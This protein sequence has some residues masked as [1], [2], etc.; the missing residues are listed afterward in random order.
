MSKPKTRRN[1]SIKEKAEILFR[2]ENGAS[3]AQLSKELGVSHSTISTIFKDRK[4]ILESFESNKLHTKKQ[5]SCNHEDI[6]AL[7][8]KWFSFQRANNVAVDGPALQIQA[9]KFAAELKKENFECSA[10]WIQRFRQRHN[11]VFGKI[12]GESA[13]V[14]VGVPEDWLKTVWPKL[15]EEFSPKNIF[16]TDE[17]GLFF[18]LTPDRTMKFKG[19]TCAGGKFSKE[20]I[21]I[22]LTANMDGSEKK[23][24]LV[25]GKSRNPRCFKKVKVLPV[26]YENNKKAWMTSRVFEGFLRKWNSELARKGRKI[27]LLLDNC[28][29]HPKL[30]NLSHI[31][32]AFFPPNTTAVLQ[33]LDQGVI[34]SLKRNYRKI[35]MV[36]I[37]RNLENNLSTTISIFNAIVM[38]TKAWQDVTATTISNCFRH[39]G[40]ITE[41]NTPTQLSSPEIFDEDEP[42]SKWAEKLHTE[43]SAD[44]LDEFEKID[45]NVATTSALTDAEIIAAAVDEESA[46]NHLDTGEI[47][48]DEDEDFELKIATLSDALAA[49][50]AYFTSFINSILL[51]VTRM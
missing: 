44:V 37:V 34:R 21:T 1:F 36:K 48:S 35:L 9:N 51:K 39:A 16:N 40:L 43:F 41:V 23:R 30:T 42:L 29:S 25:I 17:T 14:P 2:L 26:D 38:V 12:S 33:P 31:K 3:N 24:L 19:E 32:L 18:K 49:C 15:C 45:E 5:R 46:N 28:P 47:S 10:S 4:R 6:D 7:L 11:I 20:R 22:L 13:D 27:L 8:L 50:D